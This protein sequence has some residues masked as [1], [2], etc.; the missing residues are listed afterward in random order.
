MGRRDVAGPVAVA[1]VVRPDAVV[2]DGHRPDD[3]AGLAQREPG[4]GVAG[5][6]E[7]DRLAGQPAGDGDRPERVADAREQEDVLRVD[8][9]AAGAAQVAGELIAQVREGLP[10]RRGG[11]P[12]GPGPVPCG[13]QAGVGQAGP[14]VIGDRA[15]RPRGGGGGARWYRVGGAGRYRAERARPGGGAR[16]ALDVGGPARAGD[17]EPG[18]GEL[19]VGAH[20]GGPG[21]A[22]RRGQGPGGRQPVAVVDLAAGDGVD[23]RARHLAGPGPAPPV[24]VQREVDRGGGSHQ[25]ISSEEER[26]A[27]TVR[28]RKSAIRSSSSSV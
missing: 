22:E 2:V 12:H 11:Q 18:R 3:R 16:P 6:L 17:Q 26:P 7:R 24:E 27:A 10:G 8:G 5:V 25:P 19:L 15:G 4:L 9:E 28:V 1:Q 23:Q 21:Q 20:D 14:Q 13:D